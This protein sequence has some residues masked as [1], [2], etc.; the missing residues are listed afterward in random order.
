MFLWVLRVFKIFMS[1][2]YIRVKVIPMW[3]GNITNGAT[4]ALFSFVPC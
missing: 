2:A 3:I 4:D 1:I